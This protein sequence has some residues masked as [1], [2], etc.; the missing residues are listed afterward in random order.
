MSVTLVAGDS[1]PSIFGTLTNLPDSGLTGATVRFQMRLTGSGALS[2]DEEATVVDA[3]T[4]EVRFDWDPE[5]PVV[6]AAGSYVSRWQITFADES[7]QHT[8]PENTITVDPV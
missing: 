6:P 8:E 7:I 1:S 3:A 5:G 4:G 2:L